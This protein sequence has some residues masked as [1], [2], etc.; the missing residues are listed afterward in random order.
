[1]AQTGDFN[2]LEA[3]RR[4]LFQEL[5][6][7][8]IE[9][10]SEPLICPRKTNDELPLSCAQERLWL[11][12]QLEPAS[13]AYNIP[14]FTRFRGRLDVSALERSLAEI[15]RR[16]ET[17][18]TTFPPRA[19][20]PSQI[21]FPP[22]PPFLSITDLTGLPATEREARARELAMLEVQLGFDLKIDPPFRAKLL[23]L[24]E[25]DH[26]LFL[27]MHH[28]CS[29]GWS[30]TLLTKELGELYRAFSNHEPSPLPEL[31]VQYAD[32][33]LWEKERLKGKVLD[34]N[35][36][37]WRKQL[38]DA[39]ALLELPTDCP[40]AAA[41][42]YFRGAY[43]FLSLS[44]DLS[45][46][47][48]QLSWR[49]G[50]TTFMTLLA[51]LKVLFY[52]YTAQ[53]D[54][55]IGAPVS[56]RNVASLEPLI[57]CFLNMVAL[58]TDLSGNPGFTHLIKL[59]RDTCL[60]AFAHQGLP[61]ERV[62]EE[63]QPER[64]LSHSPVFQVLFNMHNFPESEFQL[65]ELAT[66]D[67]YPPLVW[68][69][70]DLTLYATENLSRIEFTLVFN[71]EL[72]SEKRMGEMLKQFELLLT[73]I[74]RNPDGPIDSFSL[75]TQD[76]EKILPNPTQ[77]LIAGSEGCIHEIFSELAQRTPDQVAVVDP[78]QSL[79][80]AELGR[81]SNQLANCLI[82]AYD[83]KPHDVVAIFGHR[84]A[85]LVWAML[86]ILK[87][88]A[89]FLILD[90]RYPGSRLTEY[91]RIV[92]PRGFLHILAAGDLPPTLE[93]FITQQEMCCRIEIGPRPDAAMKD[94]STNA[95]PVHVNTTDLAYVTFTSGTTGVPKGVG[96]THNSLTHYPTWLKQ[97][98][99][100]NHADRFSMLSGLSHDPLLRDVFSP[101]QL[102][103]TLC[104][105]DQDDIE[106]PGK[107]ARWM[108]RERISVTNLTPAMG[109]VLTTVVSNEKPQ[110]TSLR[111]AFF[112]GETLTGYDVTRLEELAPLATCVNLYGTTETQ[113]ALSY[114]VVSHVD[115]TD[116]PERLMKAIIP[117]GSGIPNVQLLVLN[118]SQ[119][120]AGC[121]E[122][123]EI[124]FRS[125]HLAQGY[126][127]DDDLTRKHFPINPFTRD[128]SDRLYRTGDLGRYRPNGNVEILGRADDQIKI[129]GF[130]VEPGEVETIVKTLPGVSDCKVVQRQHKDGTNRLVAYVVLNSDSS[131][132]AGELRGLL[133]QHLPYYMI[134]SAFVFLEKI[135]ITP[136]GKVDYRALPDDTIVELASD[137]AYA[138]P[139]TSLEEALLGIWS[140]VLGVENIGIHDDFFALGGH[141]LL[142]MK[143]LSQTREMLHALHVDV[144]LRTLFEASTISKFARRIE[145][146][147]QAGRQT[148]A[149]RIDRT[150]RNRRLPL[151]LVQEGWL[152][153]EWWEEVHS[154][155][156]RSFHLMATLGLDG[157]LDLSI[158]E[159]SINEIIRRHEVLRSTFSIANGLLSQRKLFPL[160]R[161]LFALGEIQNKL[162]RFNNR[163]SKTE[164]PAF[165]GG[166][167]VNL[168]P[169][170]D[171][172]VR[173]IDLQQLD[174]EARRSR[175]SQLINEELQKSF[176]Y[177]HGPLVRATV[178]RLGRDDHVLC[179]VVHHLLADGW[180]MQILLRELSAL[181]TSYSSGAESPL[182]ELPFQYVDFAAWQ[183][184]WFQDEVLESMIQYWKQQFDGVGLFPELTLPFIKKN[185]TP[186]FQRRVEVQSLTLSSE[187][188]KSLIQFGYRQG[189]TMYMLFLAAL[190]AL[191]FLYTGREKISVFSPLANRSLP[192]TQGLIGWF[193]NIHALTT[194]CSGNPTFSTFLRRIR[195]VALGAYAHQEV[196][197]FLLIKA[198]LP[199]MKNY[200]MPQKIFEVPHVM[201]DFSVQRGTGQTLGNLTTRRI[202]IPPS[203]ADAGIEFKV[204]ES[205]EGFKWTVKYSTEI[206]DAGDV[207]RMLEEL[208][209][210]LE[211]VV[212]NPEIRLRDLPMVGA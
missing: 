160:F 23:K 138:G 55:I 105:P 202:E 68:S 13:P 177:T 192:E 114:F 183:R 19:D 154:V 52:R 46:A 201:F 85:A 143:L 30:R 5:L 149:V 90:P 153:R 89:A 49:E 128:D 96:G 18:R 170:V 156:R 67:F 50:A 77:E 102:G 59:V 11:L 92:K 157:P 76:W 10:P 210:L 32:Y 80:Y 47:L 121:G 147:M 28:I 209:M 126:L 187:H 12:D 171:L 196:P 6:R 166:P 70:F 16:H 188:S 206:V 94:Y 139:T 87:A 69:K 26:A 91:L 132:R 189:L 207:R 173:L 41:R 37:Y 1:M 111:F 136:N 116:S 159:K 100:I 66:Q 88:G 24:G 40:R 161:K 104:I 75:V 81:Q 165:L 118:R 39:P 129:R 7:E 72:F 97:A 58:R 190:K 21:I 122:L 179:I 191:L 83:I 151:S 57:G 146:A 9:P 169:Q 4:R 180:S 109:Q 174:E 56:G 115:K 140:Q 150:S 211:C 33:A 51:A 175:T 2:D 155:E 131:T 203:S 205:R 17:L 158:V 35:L 101:L 74:V 98:F 112:V 120:L 71:S 135:P 106:V 194:D 208:Q 61:F 36:G 172:P 62:I 14:K 73:Q 117:A 162:S 176:D 125:P 64:S 54:I 48:K 200:R 168:K 124:Y 63:L 60:S 127:N 134:P 86:G 82:T 167:S 148:R 95:P 198:L 20:L 119:Q 15:V 38:Q 108:L 163:I 84:S 142:A 204:I 53:T 186:G 113:R 44:Q 45:D 181:Y 103:A 22:T 137:K 141:S 93:E 110:L 178:L 42:A 164:T 78:H 212:D 29:D 123:G 79:S 8:G 185:P 199:E 130:R 152:L 27:T 195:E 34:D 182:P 25:E 197:Y 184:R 144:P 145:Q 43:H 99:Q 3:T 31:P 107:L 133:K 193:A 65:P